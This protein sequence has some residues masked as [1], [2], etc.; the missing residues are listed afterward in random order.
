MANTFNNVVDKIFARSLMALRN[1]TTLPRLVLTDWKNEIAK[2]GNT[3]DVQLPPS[4]TVGDVTPSQVPPAGQ[5]I[6]RDTVAIPLSYWRGTEMHMTDKEA[7]EIADGARAGDLSEVMSVLAD[8]VNSKIMA[9]Y[10]DVYGYAGVAGVT[11]FATDLSEAVDA[12]KVL[13]DQKA[14]KPDRSIVIDGSAE[15]NA[16]KLRQVLDQ[17][18]KGNQ[19]EN[20]QLTGEI[21]AAL[22]FR[23]F[24]DQQVQTHSN[25]TT[26]GAYLVNGVNAIGTTSL[27]VDTGTGTLLQGTVFTIAGDTQTYV[28]TADYAGGAGNVSIS[29]AL[30]VA[31]SGGEAIT[32]KAAHVVNLA[33]QRGAFALAV[34]PLEP[35]D[36]FSGGNI[37][38]TEMDPETG[39]GITLEVSREHKRIKW[40]WSIL[41]GVKCIRPELAARIAG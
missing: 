40:H 2:K 22:G 18:F 11:P 41:Y 1:A 10:K 33:F 12:R 17:S 37:V 28:V 34:R 35:A 19:G 5:D 32:E 6:T 15:A 27:A 24:A 29:P 36:G 16:L 3:I 30:K 39:L 13:F 21:G 14:P 20:T 8:D 26:D 7:R 38:R 9:L 25:G 31:T 23:W 4:M